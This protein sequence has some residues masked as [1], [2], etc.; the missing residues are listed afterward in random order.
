MTATLENVDGRL[1]DLEEEMT[2]LR[3]FQAQERERKALEYA[4]YEGELEEITET[5]GNVRPLPPLGPLVSTAGERL[6]DLLPGPPL[7]RDQME[8]DRNQTMNTS[9]QRRKEFV[10]REKHITVRPVAISRS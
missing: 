7:R 6:A 9:N 10:A 8:A 3:A 1:K 2:E 5:L 4:M